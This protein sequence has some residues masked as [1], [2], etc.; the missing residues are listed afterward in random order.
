MNARGALSVVFPKHWSSLH[1]PIL[2]LF[3]AFFV[4]WSI[5]VVGPNTQIFRVLKLQF[6]NTF[7]IKVSDMNTLVDSL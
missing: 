2:L 7:N 4:Q 5:T 3:Y 1:G 6:Y